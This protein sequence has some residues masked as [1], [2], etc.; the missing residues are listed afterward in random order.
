MP[1][2][3][4]LGEDFTTLLRTH[5]NTVGN[6][7]PAQLIHRVFI[8]AF[9]RQIAVL[10]ILFQ[11]ALAFQIPGQTVRDGVDEL[12]KLVVRRCLN[13]AKSGCGTFVFHID[14]IEKQ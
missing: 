8:C 10:G 9:Q 4:T 3:G 5:G 12:C 7:M 2:V 6:G 13:P 11:Q 1:T 14:T